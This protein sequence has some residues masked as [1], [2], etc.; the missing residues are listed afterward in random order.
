MLSINRP[1][2]LVSTVVGADYRRV[3]TLVHELA[4]KL[5][6]CSPEAFSSNRDRDRKNR[7]GITFHSGSIRSFWMM[8]DHHVYGNRFAR[9]KS[10]KKSER[11]L[12][13]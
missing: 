4:Q 11:L 5:S 1:I 10:T 12:H 13:G 7:D 9:L 6:N 3:K 8:R 2:L